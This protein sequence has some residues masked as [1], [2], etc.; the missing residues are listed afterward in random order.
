MPTV[1]QIY[2]FA[3]LGGRHLG[4]FRLGGT[5][6]G[7]MLLPWARYRIA[8]NKFNLTPLAPT[9]E[10][11]KLGPLLRRERDL[12]HYAGLFQ[13][14]PGE[15]K[16][17][18]KWLT[19][20]VAR[21]VSED[22]LVEACAKRSS[23]PR[24]VIFKGVDRF[25]KVLHEYTLLRSEL[26]A[27]TLPEHTSGLSVDFTN[28]ISVHMR[29]GDFKLG[30][31]HTPLS[32]YKE[33]IAKLRKLM[34]LETKVFV[35]SDG[36]TEEVAPLL[37]MGNAERVSYGSSIADILALARANVLVATSGSSFSSWASLLGRMPVVWPPGAIEYNRLYFDAPDLEIECAEAAP[38][39]A[40]FLTYIRNHRCR[41]TWS[42]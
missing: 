1:N 22:S 7:N 40:P 36:T 10:Q 17:I 35:F 33:Q 32:W 30:N 23:F 41:D 5:G 8:T 29:C 31:M 27:M 21:R 26:V 16:G 2:S 28:T 34:G 4:L 37:A 24:L 14:L 6:L 18:K 15:I 3:H 13:P 20:R 38:L 9:W 25:D 19:L 42:Q 12:R 39:P 11:A